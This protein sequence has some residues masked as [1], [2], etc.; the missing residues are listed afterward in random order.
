MHAIKVKIVIRKN[1]KISITKHQ[2]E[3]KTHKQKSGTERKRLHEAGY[4]TPF[5]C[6]KWPEPKPVFSSVLP[7]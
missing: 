6:V 3:V 1:M 4:L 2:T 5:Y 7:Q